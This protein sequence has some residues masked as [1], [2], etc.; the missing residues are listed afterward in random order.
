MISENNQTFIDN[1]ID[2][3]IVVY[4]LCNLNYCNQKIKAKTY[5]LDLTRF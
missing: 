3:R 5:E 1:I 4:G 2:V